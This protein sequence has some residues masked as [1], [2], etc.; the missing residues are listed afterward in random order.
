MT[1]AGLNARRSRRFPASCE[2]VPQ[3]G[4][5][6]PSVVIDR[7]LW[8]VVWLNSTYWES[9]YVI[10]ILVGHVNLEATILSRIR[11]QFSSKDRGR[12]LGLLE[13]CEGLAVIILEH[14]G[15]V[16]DIEKVPQFRFPLSCFQQTR[17]GVD[18][19]APLHGSDGQLGALVLGCFRTPLVLSVLR[20]RACGG[21]CLLTCLALG[22][23]PEGWPTLI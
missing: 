19:S 4:I 2:I 17:I 21:L 1:L 6:R 15:A 5:V 8:W 20:C 10:P 14:T 12:R 7:G 11:R 9:R 23:R 13:G 18:R 3:R 22:R 16:T